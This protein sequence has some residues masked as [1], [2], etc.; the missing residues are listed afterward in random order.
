MKMKE[1]SFP[2]SVSLI[3]RSIQAENL[4]FQDREPW[5]CN[6]LLEKSSSLNFS[7]R[8]Q[9]LRSS[10]ATNF[11][12]SPFFGVFS[13]SDFSIQLEN[14]IGLFYLNLKKPKSK[15]KKFR[16]MKNFNGIIASSVGM[17]LISFLRNDQSIASAIQQCDI[18]RAKSFSFSWHYTEI[19]NIFSRAFFA[20]MTIQCYFH[21]IATK[22]CTPSR[23]SN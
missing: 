11:F 13:Y 5:K 14:V 8:R 20:R 15:E 21:S 17:I 4:I 7:R 9:S 12:F 6:I 19:R 16:C 2:I 22:F 3:W 18:V 1:K 10:N 23:S